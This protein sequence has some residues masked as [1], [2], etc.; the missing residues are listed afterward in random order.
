MEWN[1]NPF[2]RNTLVSIFSNGSEAESWCGSNCDHCIRKDK[3]ELETA[4]LS[5]WADYGRIPL[6]V[7]KEIGCEYN[8]LYQQASLSAQCRGFRTGDEPF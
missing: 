4:I 7:A 2:A 1:D 5:G 8:P 6:W 3:C